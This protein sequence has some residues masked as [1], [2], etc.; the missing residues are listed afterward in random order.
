MSTTKFHLFFSSGSG[1]SFP[2]DAGDS[3]LPAMFFTI[4]A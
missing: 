2:A 4:V 1:C 3:S